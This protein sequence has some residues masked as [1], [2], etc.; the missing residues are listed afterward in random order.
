[1]HLD[2]TSWIS[3]WRMRAH[4][5]TYVSHHVLR[6]S[7]NFSPTTRA[8]S[9]TSIPSYFNQVTKYND[10]CFVSCSVFD[11]RLTRFDF[12]ST[13]G[14]F[15][16]SSHT[17]QHLVH[18]FWLWPIAGWVKNRYLTLTMSWAHVSSI[19]AKVSHSKAHA[20]KYSPAQGSTQKLCSQ[21]SKDSTD[22]TKWRRPRNL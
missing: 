12:N 3:F 17:I 21:D 2:C 19:T 22:D 4:A 16:Q 5:S 18:R 14:A 15:I 20:M 7:F 9:S 11:L 8:S 13:P 1:M 6:D 10:S